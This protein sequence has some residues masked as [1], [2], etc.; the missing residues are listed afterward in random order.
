MTVTTD[1][2]PAGQPDSVKALRGASE[3]TQGLI[4]RIANDGPDMIQDAFDNALSLSAYLES[5]SPSAADEPDAFNRVLAGL[6]IATRS[7][8]LHG[9]RASTWSDLERAGKGKGDISVGR[10]LA[11]ELLNRAYREGLRYG[12]SRFSPANSEVRRFYGSASP[13]SEVLNPEFMM[14]TPT[15]AKARQPLLA[16]MV[17]ME[18]GVPTDVFKHVFIADSPTRQRMRRVS[19][20]AEMPTVALTVSD[21]SNTTYKYGVAIEISD[22]AVRRVAL[23]MIRFSV[24]KIAGQRMLDKQADLTAILLAGDGNSSTAATVYALTTLDSGATAGTPTAKAILTWLS[25]FEQL[26]YVPTMALGKQATKVAVQLANYGTANHPLFAL[27]GALGAALAGGNDPQ[28][29]VM[30][31]IFTSPDVT[32]NYLLGFDASVAAGMAFE[33]GAS[34]TETDRYIKS[35]TSVIAISDVT[36]FFILDATGTLVLNIGA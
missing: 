19:E 8:S 29:V 31:P 11:P 12:T 35:Q 33:T 23:D 7:S 26:G 36:G 18:T 25:T 30:P 1:A 10:T 5:E 22:E 3:A 16:S 17:A 13:V 9:V 15:I 28:E 2:V 4:N 6:G 24:A 32:T 14:T 20:R 34:K 27:S 21:H